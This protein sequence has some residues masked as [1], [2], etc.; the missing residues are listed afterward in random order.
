MDS[1]QPSSCRANTL[2]YRC[3]L[4]I[5]KRDNYLV[6]DVAWHHRRL[7]A[8][9]PSGILS[10]CILLI[11]D[12]L[13]LCAPLFGLETPSC[14][15]GYLWTCLVLIKL[16]ALDSCVIVAMRITYV[17]DTV[18]AFRTIDM[19]CGKTSIHG[20]F[21]HNLSFRMAVCLIML[22]TCAAIVINESSVLV[23][24]S[25][26]RTLSNVNVANIYK[27]RERDRES[28]Y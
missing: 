23:R 17:S 21:S 27:E 18:R 7:Y 11:W 19:G 4:S 13:L 10:H 14:Q 28:R 25:W 9:D 24:W 15:L 5:P 6:S 20:T 16:M 2:H 26:G 12:R 22:S 3:L 8:Q 1:L